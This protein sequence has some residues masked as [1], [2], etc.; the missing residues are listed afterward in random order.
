MGFGSD[1]ATGVPVA[2]YPVI[3]VTFFPLLSI[4]IYAFT[5]PSGDANWSSRG[6]ESELTSGS[7]LSSPRSHVPAFRGAI[8]SRHP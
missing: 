5:G 4:A 3:W 6:G 8:N 2:S 7:G 1:A